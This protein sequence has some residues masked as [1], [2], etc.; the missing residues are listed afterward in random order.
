MQTDLISIY[1]KNGVIE[2]DNIFETSLVDKW[3]KILEPYYAG[4]RDKVS[5][6]LT[7]L[8]EDGLDILKG[9]FNDKIKFITSKL[10]KDPIVFYAGSNEIPANTKISHVNHNEIGGWHTD[11]GENLQY[12]DSR[13]PYW[14]TFFV[15]LTDVEKNDGPFEITNV[16]RK[17]DINN[18]TKT[19]SIIGKKGK[20]FLWGNPFYHRAAPNLGNTRRRILKI[21]VQHNYLQSSYNDKLKKFHNLLKK[22]DIYF[23]Y[24][25]GRS[26]HSGYRDWPL[27]YKFKSE[28]IEIINRDHDSKVYLSFSRAIKQRIK[29]LFNVN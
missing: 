8:G 23:S 17:K 3:N 21:Q 12:L 24:L 25:T 1:K 11:T 20:C 26:H 5:I 4:S 16:T 9:F 2:F 27:N 10:I 19:F 18:N 22:E 14:I 6:D 7:D 15:Y 29:N 13:K 28:N